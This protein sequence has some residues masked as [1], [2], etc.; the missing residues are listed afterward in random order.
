MAAILSRPQCVN[1]KVITVI[2]LEH[3][4]QY[5]GTTS[6][7]RVCKLDFCLYFVMD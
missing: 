5:V 2:D 3:M 6:E 4:T 1:S 7:N